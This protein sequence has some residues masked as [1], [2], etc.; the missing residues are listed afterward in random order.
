MTKILVI[1]AVFDEK[2]YFPTYAVRA[3]Y[4]K[5]IFAYDMEPIFLPTIA[6]SELIKENYEKCSGVL[7]MGG[8]DI[9]PS[10][11]GSSFDPK[12]DIEDA[13]RDEVE[14][15]IARLAIKDQKP[16]LGICRG[17]QILN[18]AQ[19]GTLIQHIPEKFENEQHGISEGGNYDDLRKSAHSN[20]ININRDSN[21]G[22]LL[23]KSEA[24]VACGHHQAVDKIGKDLKITAKSQLGVVE[25]IEHVDPNY[26][27]LG[28]QFHPEV[29]EDNELEIIFTSFFEACKKWKK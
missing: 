15:Y 8:K 13:L 12:T 18:V 4:L 29:Y 3:S 25:A 17:C 22:N 21:L 11:Y 10:H 27:C 19:G 6:P 20:K 7:L 2:N 26:F 28:V 1:M 5:K 9:N 24:V 14:L 16:F 23:N